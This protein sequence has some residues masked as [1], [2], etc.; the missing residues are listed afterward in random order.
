MPKTQYE[1]D[2]EQEANDLKEVLKTAHGKRLLMRL[3]N[4]AGVHKPTYATG[5]QPTDFAFLEGRREFGLFLLAEITK[6]STDAWLDMQK[7]HF[8]Q[9]QLNNEKVKHEREQQRAINS[10]N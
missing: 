1:L 3:I 9:S 7:E 10:D 2:Q 4:R 6:V 5:T 8:K